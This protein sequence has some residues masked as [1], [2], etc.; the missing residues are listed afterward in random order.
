MTTVVSAFLGM[1]KQIELQS[2]RRHRLPVEP[3]ERFLM[4]TVAFAGELDLLVNAAA[5]F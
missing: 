5:S 3:V 2:H 1:A 4:V